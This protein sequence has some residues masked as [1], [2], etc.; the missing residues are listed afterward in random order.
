MGRLRKISLLALAGCGV[1]LLCI[2]PSFTPSPAYSDVVF[3]D[4]G[5]TGGR[6]VFEAELRGRLLAVDLSAAWN[7][8]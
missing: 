8:P 3:L 7:S 6:W 4:Q 2:R 5:W 1:A